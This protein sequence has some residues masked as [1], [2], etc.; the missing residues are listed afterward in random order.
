MPSRISFAELGLIQA[1]RSTTAIAAR[2][3]II[4]RYADITHLSVGRA[5]D[6]LDLWVHLL[7]QYGGSRNSR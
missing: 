2:S 7:K 1:Y 6:A 4:R 5:E 3:P